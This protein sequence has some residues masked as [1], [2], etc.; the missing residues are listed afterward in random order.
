MVFCVRGMGIMACPACSAFLLLYMQGMEIHLPIPEG[1][2]CLS[3]FNRYH[4]FF[5]AEEAKAVLAIFILCIKLFREGK[6]ENQGIIRSVGIMTGSTVTLDH[7]PVLELHGLPYPPLFMA[8]IAEEINF[9]KQLVLFRRGMGRMA[10]SALPFNRRL[11]LY[12]II[13]NFILF[14]LMTGKTEL[15]GRFPESQPV[16]SGMG[17]VTARTP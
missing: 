5:M 16:I 4:G 3:L 12:L 14:L 1:C 13:G 10:F 7:G 9:I 11:M 6:T 15:L 2:Y 8:R 17:V